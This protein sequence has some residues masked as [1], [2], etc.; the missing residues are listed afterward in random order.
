MQ[1]RRRDEH[2]PRRA[3][4]ARQLGGKTLRIQGMDCADEAAVL[5]R[6]IGP[7]VG[8]GDNLAFDLPNGR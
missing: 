4:G 5:R 8:G 2:G 1:L 6:E 3:L 7:L